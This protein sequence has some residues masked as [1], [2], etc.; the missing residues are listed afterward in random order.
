[1]DIEESSNNPGEPQEYEEDSSLGIFTFLAAILNAMALLFLFVFGPLL[2]HGGS[3]R[4][5]WIAIATCMAIS[6]LG[7]IFGMRAL[8]Q[9]RYQ[10]T[11]VFGTFY[12]FCILFGLIAV[13]LICC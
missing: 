1:M 6:L 3:G 11:Y 13:T 2:V 10:Q 8:Y 7:A 12:H 4:P 9:G 5:L